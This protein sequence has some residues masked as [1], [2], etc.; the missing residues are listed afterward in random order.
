ML[1][2][3][4]QDPNF[5]RFEQSKDTRVR[6]WMIFFVVLIMPVVVVF[7]IKS[8]ELALS[9]L[10][11]EMLA[12]GIGV[13]V[14]WILP[15]RQSPSTNTLT[16]MLLIILVVGVPTNLYA[17]TIDNNSIGI[18]QT[19]LNTYIAENTHTYQSVV[20]SAKSYETQS[21]FL[22]WCWGS[23]KEVVIFT[24]PSGILINQDYVCSYFTP[25]QNVN[26]TASPTFT[27]Q[28]LQ[29]PTDTNNP[30]A[31]LALSEDFNASQ[32]QITGYTYTIQDIPGGC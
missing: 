23:P 2:G 17:L 3:L 32:A 19:T 18:G 27:Y 7:I 12:G 29:Y 30:F 4:T 21:C 22:F 31:T 14:L 15:A 8:V 6:D 9:L 25:N 13:F 5:E 1:K 26:I 10:A 24:T 11:L 20:T 16:Y 28:G